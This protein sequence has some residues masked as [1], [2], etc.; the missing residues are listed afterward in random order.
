MIGSLLSITIVVVATSFL[1]KNTILWIIL[2][3]LNIPVYF[4]FAKKFLQ[5]SKDMNFSL[6]NLFHSETI[7]ATE[8]ESWAGYYGWVFIALCL[9]VVTTEYKLISWYIE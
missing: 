8:D 5:N 9:A 7:R 3:L 6:D 2:L 4:V 1:A